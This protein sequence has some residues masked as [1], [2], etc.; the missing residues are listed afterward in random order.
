[1][2]QKHLILGVVFVGTVIAAIFA[3]PPTD[4]LVASGR[5][6]ARRSASVRTKIKSVV[7]V[8]SSRQA[9]D[10][11]LLSIRPRVAN[12]DDEEVFAQ[13]F[14]K[15]PVIQEVVQEVKAEPAPPEAPPLPFKIL[16]LYSEGNQHG[17]FLQL[18]DQYLVVHAGDIVNATYKVISYK[19]GVLD[20]EYLP[21]GLH[22]TLVVSR[23][24]E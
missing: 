16:G 12:D 11:A 18:N 17:V 10:G 3:P 2:K 7:E 15:P 22:Q 23:P 8:S 19:N 6:E 4:E 9:S 1:M 13:V 14:W 24:D 5:A 20:F 21:L